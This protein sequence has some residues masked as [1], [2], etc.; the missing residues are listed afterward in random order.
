MTNLNGLLRAF[1]SPSIAPTAKWLEQV[2]IKNY[3]DAIIHLEDF[4]KAQRFKIKH[5]ESSAQE[6][7][8]K[9]PF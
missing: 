7:V 5:S 6:L 8:I 9:L 1:A 4:A 2:L 3:H